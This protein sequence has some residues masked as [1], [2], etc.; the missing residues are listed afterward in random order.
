M[1]IFPLTPIPHGGVTG[2]FVLL[3]LASIS[4]A[5]CYGGGGNCPHGICNEE[6]SPKPPEK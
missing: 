3:L 5:G 6:S 1:T 4:M 2:I